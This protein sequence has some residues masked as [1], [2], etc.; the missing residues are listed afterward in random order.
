MNS[1]SQSLTETQK[2]S[3][4]FLRAHSRSRTMRLVPVRSC[5]TCQDR[6][7]GW[8]PHVT[9]GVSSRDREVELLLVGLCVWDVRV[10]ACVR[11]DCWWKWKSW[12]VAEMS[13]QVEKTRNRSKGRQKRGGKEAH[14][15]KIL[16]IFYHPLCAKEHF[17]SCR[18]V[19]LTLFR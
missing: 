14:L 13:K 12:G 16:I 9:A 5:G 6:A 19:V 18:E 10:F 8:M 7:A 11:D 4:G 3:R 15:F 17:R 1:F 2:G